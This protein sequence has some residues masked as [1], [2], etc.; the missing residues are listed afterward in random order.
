[1]RIARHCAAE[2][3][4]V[5]CVVTKVNEPYVSC[6]TVSLMY[7]RLAI[8]YSP[9]SNLESIHNGIIVLLSVYNRPL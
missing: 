1:M 8:C 4:H 6:N 9:P 5:I 3:Q 7:T 2:L